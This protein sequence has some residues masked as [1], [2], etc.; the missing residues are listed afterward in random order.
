MTTHAR[1]AHHARLPRLTR[2][3]YA[4]AVC[5]EFVLLYPVYALLFE[6]SGLSV[7]QISSLFVIWSLTAVVLAVP[8][9]A[10]ADLVPRR[11]LLALAPLLTGTGFA[12]WLL[13]PSY[14]AFAAGFVLWGAGGALASGALE[15]LVHTEL[16]HR[17]AADHYARVM[18]ITR[19][20]GVAS[21]GAAA[22]LAV[23]AMALGGYTAVGTASIAVC[24]LGA[25]AG[26]ALPEHR[27]TT[28]AHTHDEPEPGYAAT[29]RS[30]LHEARTSRPVRHALILLV[31]ATAFW[32]SLEEYI[33]LLASDAGVPAAQV[34]AVLLVVWAFVT[35]GG[36]LA[37]RA[38]LWPR[39]VLGLALLTATL[40]AA[41]GAHLG[42]W[43]GWVLLGA[44]FALYQMLAVVADARLQQ[45]IT[46]RARATVT[47]LAGLGTE[48]VA[49][50]VF[51]TYAG[52][53]TGLGHPAV[54][55]LFVLPYA[56]IGVI[57]A[58]PHRHPRGHT[59]R[60]R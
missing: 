51:A 47:S 22:L 34:P 33:P 24:L 7:S 50:A 32:E 5:Q 59:P 16:D 30:G 25:L 52:L 3:L 21:V 2:P 19:A 27:T 8:C 18:G 4:Y 26:L 42:T 49:I 14:P 9:G 41:A 46:G 29:L 11:H 56:L 12:L 58:A 37:A 31:V 38:A 45:T 55:T 44:G 60:S 23:P 54:F 10:L 20:L 39:P 1:R 28:P 13:A 48:A 35:T 43:A 6:R 15:A 57:M 36:L 40:A 53:S 17:G